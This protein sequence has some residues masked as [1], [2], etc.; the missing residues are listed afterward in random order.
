MKPD[1]TREKNEKSTPIGIVYSG[2]IKHAGERF[3]ISVHVGNMELRVPHGSPYQ[4]KNVS[5]DPL[6]VMSPAGEPVTIAPFE[7]VT[8]NNTDEQLAAANNRIAEL[9]QPLKARILE[10]FKDRCKDMDMMQMMWAEVELSK[11]LDELKIK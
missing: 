11:V 4:I 6:R 5:N 7:A 10:A 2:D 1:E 3:D 9:E 8:F